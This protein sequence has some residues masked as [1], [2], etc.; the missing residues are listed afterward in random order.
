MF[1]YFHFFS[2]GQKSLFY[3]LEQL[4]NILKYSPYRFSL[5]PQ[6]SGQQQLKEKKKKSCPVHPFTT[7]KI[8]FLSGKLKRTGEHCSVPEKS[9]HTGFF[10]SKREMPSEVPRASSHS[11]QKKS[12]SLSFL[13]D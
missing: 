11:Y 12:A 1:I 13:M 7:F 5:I 2:S 3:Y 8:L 9:V 10:R 4:A 6:I